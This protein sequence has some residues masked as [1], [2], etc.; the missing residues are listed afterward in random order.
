MAPSQLVAVEA[1]D[2]V[3]PVDLVAVAAVDLVDFRQKEEQNK[4]ELLEYF[5]RQF[6]SDVLEM[7]MELLEYEMESRQLVA[8]DD[9]FS[10]LL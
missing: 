5:W 8:R 2:L 6:G 3:A 10:K 9:V 7:Q 4:R 1:A